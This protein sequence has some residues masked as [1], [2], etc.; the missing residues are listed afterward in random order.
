M[1]DKNIA[2]QEGVNLFG[3]FFKHRRILHHLVVDAC[4]TLD[5]LWDGLVRVDKGL[6]LFDYI[7]TIKNLDAYLDNPISGG[8]TSGSFDIYNGK[9]HN[10]KVSELQYVQQVPGGEVYLCDL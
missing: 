4:K 6:E 2:L 8:I 5:V 10:R 3:Y 9:C 1:C 7:L